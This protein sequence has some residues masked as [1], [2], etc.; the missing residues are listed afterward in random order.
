M[1]VQSPTRAFCTKGSSS[2]SKGVDQDPN[3]SRVLPLS[4]FF[5]YKENVVRVYSNSGEK[6][7]NAEDA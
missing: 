5:S 1:T 2:G 7:V 6:G 4:S 3:S